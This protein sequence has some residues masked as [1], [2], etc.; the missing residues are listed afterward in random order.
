MSKFLVFNHL[1]TYIDDFH[2]I[3]IYIGTN[4]FLLDTMLFF[5]KST[6]HA[7][8]TRSHNRLLENLVTYPS[9]V[10]IYSPKLYVHVTLLCALENSPLYSIMCMYINLN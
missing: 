9:C 1:R 6:N 5:L 7:D 2:S 4:N 10:Q 3:Y 8:F